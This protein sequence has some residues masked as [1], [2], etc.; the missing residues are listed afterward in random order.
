[1]TP[2]EHRLYCERVEAERCRRDM[3]RYMEKVAWPVVEPGTKFKDNWHLHQICE[4]LD[5]VLKNQVGNLLINMP[6]RFMKSLLVAV[7]FPTFAW[8]DQ[9]AMRFIYASYS[10]NLSTRDA[11][12]SRRVIESNLYQ[13]YYGDIYQLTSDQNVKTRYDNSRTGSRLTSSVGGV[14]TGEGGDVIVVDDPHNVLESDSD[15]TREEA[16]RW[17]KET[18]S[19]RL[20]DPDLGHKIIVMQRV[21]ENDLAGEMIREGGYE[22]LC[23][24]MHF[25]E[26]R[27]IVNGYTARKEEAKDPRTKEG[28]LAWPARYSAGAIAV[29]EVAMGAYA[30]AGQFQQRPSP[31]GGSLFAP[32][33]IEILDICPAG[34]ITWVRAWD[35]AATEEK[36]GVKPAYTAGIKVGRDK[37]NRI[38]IANMKR[39]RLGPLGVELLI[40]NTASQDGKSVKISLPQD[41][42]QAGK[43]QKNTYIGKLIGYNVSAT[44]ETGSKMQ[45]AEP[46]AAQVEAG[47]VFMVRGPWNEEF[48]NELR[49][50]PTGTF[51]DQVDAF[52]RAIGEL[53]EPPSGAEN[54]L[55]W[56][57][58]KAERLKAEQEK[59]DKQV[60]G[61]QT[62]LVGMVRNHA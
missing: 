7:G 41:P 59:R 24:P 38:I 54:F 10:A 20:N 26:K 29:M 3:H 55:A 32:D 45:R 33:L 48:I 36:T 61:T 16:V 2:L 22:H 47:N 18:M 21:H 34:P 6:P 52:S 14:G 44:P 9:P 25:E 49:T 37:H 58:A 42:G 19:T 4:A 27:V 35:L 46:A 43:V 53:T 12:K 8:I 1:M 31:R 57:T 56:A 13:D 51:K 30:V 50:F 23:I 39:E 40:T 15:T 11:V 28:E 5:A 62:T 60:S 17:W